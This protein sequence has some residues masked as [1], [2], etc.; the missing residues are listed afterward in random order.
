MFEGRYTCDNCGAV[1][2]QVNKWFVSVPGSGIRILGFTEKLGR[3]KGNICLCGETC[4]HA[5]VSQLAP[6]L[7]AVIPETGEE[8]P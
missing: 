1:R 2:K 8:N 3:K 6:T 7:H 4:L 5:H